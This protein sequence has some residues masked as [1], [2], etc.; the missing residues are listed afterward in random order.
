M[1][2]ESMGLGAVLIFDD[3]AG[4]AGIQ[5]SSAA[6]DQLGGS[7]TKATG[8]MAQAQTQVNALDASF[9]NISAGIGQ[10]GT[11]MKS[12][13]ML[14]TGIGIAVGMAG[15]MAVDFEAQMA[16]VKSIGAPITDPT[17]LASDMA[18]L[19][20]EAKRLG[21]ATQFTATEAGQAMEIMARA[22]FSAK[23]TMGAVGGVLNAAA[24]E[25]MS[26]ADAADVVALNIRAFNKPASEAAK[27]ADQLAV[28]SASTNTSILGLQEGLKYI[29]PIAAQAG[30]SFEE[31]VTALGLMADAGFKNTLGG[32]ALKNAFLAMASPTKKQQE[33]ME[34][35]GLTIRDANGNFIG[36]EATLRQL[37]KGMNS[38]GGKVDRAA[39]A[40]DLLGLRGIGLTSVLSRLDKQG[41][42]GALTFSEL[43]AKIMKADG[44]AKIMADTR[45]DSFK[46]QWTILTSAIEGFTIELFEGP[47]VGLKQMVTRATDSVSAI[48]L[49]IQRIK[50]L[51]AGEEFPITGMPEAIAW[52]VVRGID[53]VKTGIT[54]ITGMFQKASE[55]FYATFGPRAVIEIAEFAVKF[56]AVAAALAPVLGAAVTFGFVLFSVV[57]PAVK[58]L[59]LIVS[60][61]AGVLT[62]WVL[63]VLAAIGVAGFVAFS[64]LREEGESFGDTALRV[65]QNIKDAA[66]YVFEQVLIPYWQGLSAAF[67]P[68][69]EELQVIWTETI[70]IIKASMEDIAAQFA[71]TTGGAELNW[72]DLGMTLGTILGTIVVT[73]A[74]VVAFIIKAWASLAPTFVWFYRTF[75]TF[76]ITPLQMA[77]NHVR[78]VLDAVQMLYEGGVLSGLARLGVAILD[79]ILVPL[80]Y[81][82]TQVTKLAELLGVDVPGAL[83]TFGREGLSGLIW[84]E[85]PGVPPVAVQKAGGPAA[86]AAGLTPAVPA[87]VGAELAAAKMPVIDPEKIG[88][89]VGR[90]LQKNPPKVEHTS[91]VQV[92]N[93]VSLDGKELSRGMARQQIETWERSGAK[94][95]PWQRGVLREQGVMPA[96]ATSR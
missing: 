61:L 84:P 68:V 13:A 9:K 1:A 41:K 74:E 35:M 47:L 34:K 22:G 12:A 48:V 3:A 64:L 95:P 96:P 58:G 54:T 93:K 60:G 4:V 21:A 94:T 65:W 24:A 10:V 90:A 44:A 73:V 40:S 45:L 7:V 88:E 16:V 49:S 30:M 36:L 20:A 62:S 18:M 69:L 15:K 19:T 81:V 72:K 89:H 77:Y 53:A 25:G 75:G 51:G 70:G 91:H 33:I 92:D 71:G 38:Y 87:M 32:T 46:G 39:V 57:I 2:F 67:A 79:A 80:R 56:L 76:F 14:T 85:K 50:T 82:V 6:Y 17:K 28:A 78:R 5:R 52:G 86:I 43:H 11:A 29:A 8:H 42:E 31:T 66:V 63:P 37:Q 27:V 23:E 59:A 55:W 26:L 83:K